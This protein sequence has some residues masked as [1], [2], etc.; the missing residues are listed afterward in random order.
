MRHES[1]VAVTAASMGSASPKTHL[2]LAPVGN[3]GS[4]RIVS[5]ACNCK[6]QVFL[7]LIFLGFFFFN[8][9][10]GKLLQPE[11]RI[12]GVKFANVVSGPFGTQNKTPSLRRVED[13]FITGYEGHVRVTC[14]A[15]CG[16]G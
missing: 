6:H 4:V 14:L 13:V 10:D 8:I 12:G 5:C 9:I 2:Y 16:G 11:R 7:Q 15:P 3:S 1:P